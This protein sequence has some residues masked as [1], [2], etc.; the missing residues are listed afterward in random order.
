VNCLDAETLAAWFDGGLSGA[1]LD[2][3]QSHVA[4]C[5]VVRRSSAQW[6]ARGRRLRSHSRSAAR[7]G[8]SRGPSPRGRRNRGR[9]L[10]RDSSANERRTEF[11]ACAFIAET[12]SV[13]KRR[14][15]ATTTRRAEAA[16]EPPARDRRSTHRA[17]APRRR[18]LQTM[19]YSSRRACVNEAVSVRPA[20]PAPAAAERRDEAGRTRAQRRTA[21]GRAAFA[22]NSCGPLW[23]VP[24]SDVAGQSRPRHRHRPLSAGWSGERNRSPFDRSADLAASQFFGDGRFD[25]RQG[26][27][28]PVRNRCHGGRSDVF[29]G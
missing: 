27:R 10:G 28:R 11:A 18:P 14:H 1:A 21:A 7:D 4:T 8:G 24:P 2:D 19:R 16:P 6:A 5:P 15:R 3:V 12:G 29:D 20:A 13:T 17:D 26:D 9:D 23:P 22:N 25:K